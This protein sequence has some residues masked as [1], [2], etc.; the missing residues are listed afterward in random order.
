[1]IEGLVLVLILIG[2]TVALRWVITAPETAQAVQ[3]TSDAV[4]IVTSPPPP[5]STPTRIPTWTPTSTATETPKPTATGTPRPTPTDTPAP[6]PTPSLAISLP[7][8]PVIV[9]PA[10]GLIAS[11]PLSVPAAMPLVQQGDNVVNVLVLGSDQIGIQ[12]IGRTD[13]IIIASIDP[14][15]PSISLISVPR[16][17]YAWIP[18]QGFNK[19]N[20]AFASGERIGYPGG[21]PGLLRATIEYN[22]GIR[23]H[24]YVRVGFDSFI[25]IVDALGGVDVAVECPLSD[26]FPDPDSPNGQ[27]DIDLM[28][29]I[30][31]L[32][33]KQA[34]WYA[35]SRWSTSDFDRNR[36]QQQVL[37]SLYHQALSL[38]IIPKI[39]QLWVALQETVATDMSLN[40]ILYLANVGS[41]LDMSNVKSR[42]VGRSVVH[43]WTAPNGA[44]VLVPDYAALA[45]MVSEAVAPPAV[46]RAQQRAFRVEIWNATPYSDLGPVAA[47]RL[48]WEGLEVMSIGPA[49]GTYPRTQ[50]VDFTTSSKG[51]PLPRLMQLYQLRS[52][53]VIPS[54]DED[55]PVD[56][57]VILGSNYNPCAAT[58]VE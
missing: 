27:S 12:N 3:A 16:D 29:G 51:S 33:G 52:E 7:E 19:I 22:L 43:S 46:G 20:T 41:R 34:L 11:Q 10:G 39:P 54:A 15:L 5:S 44:Y 42:F 36:R 56:F 21:G 23:T 28:P 45:T 2:A 40:E 50:I 49:D 32:S 6:T 8:A 17:F 48:R 1:M 47:E 58:K 35:R 26:T 31:H 24:Y 38:D 30:H 4:T 18:T 57:R 55:S 13:V 37:R 25:K 14:E 53:D 9:T